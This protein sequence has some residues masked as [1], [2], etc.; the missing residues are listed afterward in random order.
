MASQLKLRSQCQQ[1]KQWKPE[2]QSCFYMGQWKCSYRCL[3]DAGDFTSCGIPGF[4]C[5]CT[6]YA[7]KR[8]LL[9][10]HRASMRVMEDVIAENGLEGEVERELED[11]GNSKFHLGLCSD[12]D[13]D[14]DGD[15][16]ERVAV[17]KVREI[18]EADKEQKAF[19]EAVQGALECRAMATD[20]ERAR[21]QLEDLRGHL[22]A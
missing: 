3:H 17:E 21:M 7:K 14:S 15:D 6:G 8:R 9:R 19:V 16:P 5:G 4:V 22:R 13:E 18:R 12:M 2:G 11:T 10:R 20:L 1:W